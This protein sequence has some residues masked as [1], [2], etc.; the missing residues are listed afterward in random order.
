[1]SKFIELSETIKFINERIETKELNL[2]NYISTENMQPNKGGITKAINLPPAKTT[3][4]YK[5]N[6][7]L[8]Q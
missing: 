8:S 6:D 4:R 3:I 2:Y 5:K 1:M 7:I